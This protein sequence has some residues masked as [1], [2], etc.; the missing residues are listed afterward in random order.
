MGVANK[1]ETEF[2]SA[3][4]QEKRSRTEREEGVE[5]EPPSLEEHIRQFAAND[6]AWQKYCE[7]GE[8]DTYEEVLLYDVQHSQARARAALHAKITEAVP[9]RDVKWSYNPQQTSHQVERMH[10]LGVG[11]T[12]HFVFGMHDLGRHS[13]YEMRLDLVDSRPVVGHRQ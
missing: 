10:A 7:S 8:A 5:W 12:S 2:F 9:V 4:R 3:S 13:T 11:R 1:I 6:D